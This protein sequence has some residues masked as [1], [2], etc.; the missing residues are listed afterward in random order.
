[1]I[2]KQ[3]EK[4]Q[5]PLVVSCAASSLKQWTMN[6]LVHG[7]KG[8]A[9]EC[10]WLKAG[11]Y[12]NEFMQNDFVQNGGIS[13]SHIPANMC[14]K[15][16]DGHCLKLNVDA[17]VNKAAGKIGIGVVVRD[18]AGQLVLAAGLSCSFVVD[19]AVAEAKAILFGVQLAMSRKLFPLLIES[20]ALNVVNLYKSGTS[21][22]CDLGNIIQDIIVVCRSDGV[23]S[24][25]Y[26]PRGCN[27]VAHRI[28]KWALCF[29]SSTIWDVAFPPW[30][31]KLV[32][33]DFVSS[34][35]PCGA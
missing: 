23:I 24:I 35:A 2:A 13:S 10:F 22:R 26:V 11:F 14:W 30:L 17:S 16:P 31:R 27:F 19:V 3:E 6:Q 33:S 20:D 12:L 4:S 8:L 7:S 25:D 34:F 28:S 9:E 29:N 32:V 5:F 15:P 1:M 18:S 21:S